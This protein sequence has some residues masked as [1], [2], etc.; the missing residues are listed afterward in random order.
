MNRRDFLKIAGLGT[1]ASGV[2]VRGLW[3]LLRGGEAFA[4]EANEKTEGLRW[5]LVVDTAKCTEHPECRDCIEACHRVHNVPRFSD[6]RH[7]IKWIWREKFSGAF[8]DEGHAFIGSELLSR[9]IPVLCNHCANPPCVR[10]CPTKATFKREKDG[11]VMMDMHRCI[12]CRYCIAACPYGARSFN[13]VDPRPH[14][15]S[16]N[17]DYPTRTRGVVE[18]CTFC[19]ERVAL[20]PNDPKP[21]CVEACKYGALIFGNLGDENSEV[22][23]ALRGRLSLRRKPG[24]GTGPSVFYLV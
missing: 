24:L 18:K 8:P 1:L 23:K 9:T 17:Q 2:G 21:A 5:A 14:I 12:G 6:P 15:P 7:E 3:K 11:I 13:W 19:A 22:R 20:N 4:A 10:V 16:L